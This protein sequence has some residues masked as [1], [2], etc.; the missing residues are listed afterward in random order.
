MSIKR[1]DPSVIN[2]IAAEEVVQKPHSIIKELI[3]NSLDAHATD[4]LLSIESAG[5]DKIKLTDNG[6][7]IDP[8]DFP[9]LCERFATSKLTTYD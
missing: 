2:L 6:S 4:L 3:E 1:L 5:L 8:L 9:L 7:G